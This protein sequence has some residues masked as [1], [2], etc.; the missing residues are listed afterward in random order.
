MTHVDRVLEY[1]TAGGNGASSDIARALG[2]SRQAAHTALNKLDKR[3]LAVGDPMP[4]FTNGPPGRHWRA[5]GSTVPVNPIRMSAVTITQRRNAILTACR[6]PKTIRQ[7]QTALGVGDSEKELVRTRNLL[8][9]LIRQDM[10]I[11]RLANMRKRDGLYE[12]LD[13]PG[14]SRGWDH[15]PLEG[16]LRGWVPWHWAGQGAAA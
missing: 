10:I 3:G 2:L 9:T 15:R 16:A 7:I 14:V 5:T 8:D 4:Q 13:A 12:T 1:L 6:E 11:N